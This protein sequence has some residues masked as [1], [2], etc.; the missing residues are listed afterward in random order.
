VYIVGIDCSKFVFYYA[1]LGPGNIIVE[2][3]PKTGTVGVIDWE[4]AG[5]FPRGWIRTKFRISSGLDL[6]ATDK[7]TAWRSGVQELLADNGFEHYAP[8]W[9]SWWD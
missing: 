6:P 8:E 7:P 9:L 3:T 2:D 5:Y 4:L 1:D